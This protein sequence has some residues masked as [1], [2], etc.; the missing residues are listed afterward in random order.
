M[1]LNKISAQVFFLTLLLP[2]AP[3]M[4]QEI[5]TK[6]SEL[7]LRSIPL[8]ALFGIFKVCVYFKVVSSSKSK[9]QL[10]IVSC[11]TPKIL[12]SVC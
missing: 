11:V 5:L 9:E 1:V 7:L 2:E 3:L 8:T 10:E 6:S 4:F 12:I